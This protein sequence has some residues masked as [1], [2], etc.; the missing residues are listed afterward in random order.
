MANTNNI[1]VG[2]AKVF[3]R[4]PSD[5]ASIGSNAVLDAATGRYGKFIRGEV[6]PDGA[7]T[8]YWQGMSTSES[9]THANYATQLGTDIGFT[10][11]GIDLSI[12]PEYQDVQVDQLLDAAVI[13]KTSQKVSFKTSLTEATLENLARAIGQSVTGSVTGTL[14]TADTEKTLGLRG[15]SLGEFPTE[16]GLVAVANGPRTTVTNGKTERV[17]EAYRAI[18]VESVG[19]PVKRNEV[20]A[21]PVSFRCLPDSV[22]AY[23]IVADRVYV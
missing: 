2:G 8:G 16:V 18:S 3:V 5:S 11:D 19:I 9:V 22:G 10:N 17:F 12:E 13:F 20:T 4:N 14:T 6:T 15:G 1:I 21:F 23:I 7:N